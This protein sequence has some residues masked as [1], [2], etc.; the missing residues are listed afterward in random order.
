MTKGYRARSE[1]EKD[2][3]GKVRETRHKLP[4]TLLSGV[5]EDILNSPARGCD[6][7][8]VLPTREVHWGPHIQRF[9]MKGW[10][11]GSLCLAHAKNL[12]Y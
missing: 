12:D 9:N 1:E 10:L 5:T 6:M 7:Y 11:V 2:T 4:K 3:W 8:E